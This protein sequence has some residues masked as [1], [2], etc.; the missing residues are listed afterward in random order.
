MRTTRAKKSMAFSRSGFQALGYTDFA[1]RTDFSVIYGGFRVV[2]AVRVQN[3]ELV[4][5]S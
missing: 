1:N 4:K 2:R 5:L 3:K